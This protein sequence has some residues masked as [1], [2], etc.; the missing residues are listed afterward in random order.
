MQFFLFVSIICFIAYDGFKQLPLKR[1]GYMDY[2]RHACFNS[3]SLSS[4]NK[5]ERVKTTVDLRWEIKP[6]GYIES[7]YENK[8]GTP[9]QATISR[10]DTIKSYGKIILFDEYKDCISDLD[11]FDYIWVLS[12]M[13]LNL[14]FKKKIRPQPTADAE[15]T[16][17]QEVGLFSSRAPH[18]PNPIALSAL[19]I[20]NVDVQNGII[21]VYGLDLLNDTPILDIK[22]YIPAFDAFPST[23]FY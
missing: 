6:I 16:T 23:F 4:L 9:K 14:G 17:P 13:H 10:N 22:P 2:F 20:V 5:R 1:I 15:N 18:R 21:E 3:F 8:H 11:G 12:L 7:P 19:Q